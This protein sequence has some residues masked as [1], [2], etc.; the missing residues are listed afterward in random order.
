MVGAIWG[1]AGSGMGGCAAGKEAHDLHSRDFALNGMPILVGAQSVDALKRLHSLGQLQQPDV[2]DAEAQRAAPPKMGATSARTVG[3]DA[4]W[5]HAV[6]IHQRTLG[7][8]RR[9]SSDGPRAKLCR[10]PYSH[11]LVCAGAHSMVS[12]LWVSSERLGLLC[13][14]RGRNVMLWCLQA[15]HVVTEALQRSLT[16]FEILGNLHCHSAQVE[17]PQMEGHFAR[18]LHAEILKRD[19]AGDN[20]F[21]VVV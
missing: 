7:K 4:C 2:P 17:D 18:L 20:S 14:G 13:G 11:P 10:Y 19:T 21:Y 9:G 15:Q 5:V 8:S 12:R 3:P 16:V 1:E 6:L